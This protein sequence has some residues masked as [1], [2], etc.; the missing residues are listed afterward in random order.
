VDVDLPLAVAGLFVGFVVG[1]TGMGGG[2]LMTPMLVLLFN[3]QPLA[4]VSSDLVASFV[5]KPVGGGVHLRR[6]TVNLRLAAWLCVGSIPAAFVGVVLLRVLGDEVDD[7]LKTLLGAALLVAA[8]AMVVKG[9]LQRNRTGDTHGV[10]RVVVRPLPT[11]AI[12][13]V[14]GLVVGMT[15]VGSGSL[16]IVLLLVLYPRLTAGSLVGTDL[17]QA[18]PLVGAAALGHLFL[19]DFQLDVAG[20]LLVGALPG[21]YLGARLS[22]SA[23]DRLIRPVLV[24]VLG[25]SALK[26]LEVPNEIVG[27]LLL[28]AVIAAAIRLLRKA[29]ASR[30][31]NASRPHRRNGEG[32]AA[33]ELGSPP[34]DEAS[35]AGPVSGDTNSVR[36]EPRGK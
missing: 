27:S 32:L 31:L 26:L 11:V 28:A 18:V 35:R 20:W 13:V 7:T 4:A 24:T 6:G 5:M 2:A 1:L 14:G 36:A 22:S 8:T 16:M 30:V 34:A 12:G 10:E 3:V 19:G 33:D 15:S 25:V 17:V 29:A 21:V 9:V 23:P